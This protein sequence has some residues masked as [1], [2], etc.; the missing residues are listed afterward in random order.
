MSISNLNCLFKPVYF[1]IALHSGS[2]TVH[3][4]GKSS[5][6]S[7]SCPAYPGICLPHSEMV[8]RCPMDDAYGLAPDPSTRSSWIR[9]LSS[10]LVSRKEIL[11]L[12]LPL[13]PFGALSISL[14]SAAS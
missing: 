11:F 3:I 13:K 10:P 6:V 8:V 5:V 9:L 2:E 12:L 1:F 14:A 4:G 7:S